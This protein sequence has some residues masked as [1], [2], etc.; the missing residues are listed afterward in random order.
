MTI[1]IGLGA[2]LA[3]LSVA[4]GAC[5]GSSGTSSWQR[6]DVSGGGSSISPSQA[7]HRAHLSTT[8]TLPLKCQDC[9]VAHGGMGGGFLVG[10]GARAS[11][12][13]VAPR[14]DPA[15]GTCAVYCHGVTLTGGTATAPSWFVVDDSQKT[16][17]SCHGFPPPLPHPQLPYCTSCHDDVVAPDGTIGHPD[18]HVMGTLTVLDRPCNGCHGNSANAAPPGDLFRQAH[19][20]LLTVGAHQSHLETGMTQAIPCSECHAVP[21]EVM[22]PGHILG[23]RARVVLGPLSSR[24]G[25][26]PSYDYSTG[27]CVTYC[28]GVSLPASA[29]GATTTPVWNV[30]DGS[31]KQCTSCHALPPSD[32][33][34]GHDGYAACSICHP[35]FGAGPSAIDPSKHIGGSVYQIAN[36]LACHGAGELAALGYP[37]PPLVVSPQP[38]P[39]VDPPLTMTPTPITSALPPATANAVISFAPGS[40]DFGTVTPGA[41]VPPVALTLTNHGTTTQNF[42]SAPTLTNP[43]D[44]AIVAD[45][46]GTSNLDPDATCTVLVVATLDTETALTVSGTLLRRC[47]DDDHDTVASAQL[48]ASTLGPITFGSITIADAQAAQ[49]A[50]RFWVIPNGATVRLQLSSP[51][52]VTGLL[53]QPGG[54]LTVA[55]GATKVDLVVNGAAVIDGTISVAGAGPSNPSATPFAGGTHAGLGSD[56]LAAFGSPLAPL[57][58]GNGGSD[59]FFTDW[60][61]GGMGASG[62]GGGG[63]IHLKVAG[64]LTLGGSLV[65]DGGMGGVGGDNYCGYLRSGSGAGGSV[66]LETWSLAVHL[67]PLITASGAAPNS[68]EATGGGRIA[69]TCS[70]GCGAFPLDPAHVQARGLGGGSEGS[71]Y[72]SSGGLGTLLYANDGVAPAYQT[73]VLPGGDLTLA[74]V[75]VQDGASLQQESSSW[76]FRITDTLSIS[77]GARLSVPRNPSGP[78]F[79]AAWFPLA[80]IPSTPGVQ[81][82]VNLIE[83]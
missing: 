4:L 36:C 58:V 26:T 47:L 62:G 42:C 17:G 9:H 10:F 44:F 23:E 61:C 33:N 32:G 28:H 76:I 67:S 82:G 1:R 54:T 25:V 83:Y 63:V 12:G 21:T 29:G 69:I 52:A 78:P 79:G 51:I 50:S 3:S 34:M 13:G 81:P 77:G 75:I 14:F 43:A 5:S 55:G 16:C 53:V 68:G 64:T 37:N 30:V 6:V 46:C 73:P 57:T 48:G 39:F 65:A 56:G 71:I 74:K 38:P 27:T 8:I 60:E 31:Q 11:Y 40:Y 19:T 35:G 70:V 80:T 66:F 59:N 41:V 45:G 49:Y 18:Q 7:A 24:G 20:S 15:T 2:L 22:T 72:L